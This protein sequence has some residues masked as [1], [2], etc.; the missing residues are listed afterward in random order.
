MLSTEQNDDIGRRNFLR[1]AALVGAGAGVSLLT[2]GCSDENGDLLTSPAQDVVAGRKWLRVDSME[3]DTGVFTSVDG[4][5]DTIENAFTADVEWTGHSVLPGGEIIQMNVSIEKSCANSLSLVPA[6]GGLYHLE[7]AGVPQPPGTPYEIH[8][9]ERTIPGTDVLIITGYSYDP[10]TGK[11]VMFTVTHDPLPLWIIL[12]I[13]AGVILGTAQPAHAPT[14]SPS[15][16]PKRRVRIGNG[17]STSPSQDSA[18]G[19]SATCTTSCH[20]QG[21]GA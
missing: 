4:F 10:S 6:G 13:A 1:S 19:L 20:N 8:L 2:G 5:S 21:G 17:S 7:S 14:C 11:R 12:A 18:G 15:N 16:P 3:P 9:V